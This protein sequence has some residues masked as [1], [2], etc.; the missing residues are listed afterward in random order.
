[1]ARVDLAAILQAARED[2]AVQQ[3]T[4]PLSEI[5]RRMA[6]APPI[7]GFRDALTDGQAIIAE[8]K[9]CSPSMGNMRADN[10]QEAPCAYRETAT[11]KAVSILT[12]AQFFGGSLERLTT[13]REEIGKPVIRK[14]FIFEPYQVYQ[15]RAA[16]ADALLLMVNVL[17]SEPGRLKDLYDL[18]KSLGMDALVECH[19]APEIDQV[20]DYANLIGINSRNFKAR[21]GF[22]PRRQCGSHDVST[23]LETFDL[24]SRLPESAVKVA[25]SG[26]QSA[27][28]LQRV[29]NQGFQAALIGTS[30]LM[31][32]KGV[33]HRLQSFGEV[34]KPE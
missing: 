28:E 11:V 19:T 9:R 33:R 17:E 14:D 27:K 30:L 8:I 5:K 18:T 22:D 2:L 21:E 1:M 26:I 31:D 10:V 29:Y 13:L 12:N 6:D 7:R 25:E 34:N 24:A 16:G 4:D 20:A 15:A 3:A 23:D 32:P